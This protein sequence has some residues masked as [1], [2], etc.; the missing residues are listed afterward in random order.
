MSGLNKIKAAGNIPQAEHLDNGNSKK[1]TGDVLSPG[2]VITADISA[3][4]VYVGQGS[5][6]RIRVAAATFI[7]F[8]DS[9]IGAVTNATSPGLELNSAGVYLVSATADWVRASANPA[10]VEILEDH[11]RR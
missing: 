5:L 9:T 4:G 2:P 7:A 10:R 3:A 8:G 6:L 1:V 11:R